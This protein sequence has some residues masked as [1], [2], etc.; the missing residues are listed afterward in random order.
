MRTSEDVAPCLFFLR[1]E[2][3]RSIVMTVITGRPETFSVELRTGYGSDH[4]RDTS[5]ILSVS[6]GSRDCTVRANA[7]QA[8]NHY[9]ALTKNEQQIQTQ[10]RENFISIRS[11]AMKRLKLCPAQP[12]LA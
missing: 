5:Q 1:Y 6:R 11:I 3:R 10:K 4:S 12:L 8:E 9:K 7:R 2:L